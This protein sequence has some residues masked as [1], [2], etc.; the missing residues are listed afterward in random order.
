MTC[1]DCL[2]DCFTCTNDTKCATCNTNISYRQLNSSSRCV[3]LAGYYDDGTSNVAKPCTG[4]C[5]TCVSPGTSCLSC[6]TGSYMNGSSC[7]TCSTVISN[8]ATCT[9]ST[10]CTACKTSF[11]S[12]SATNC[13]CAAGQYLASGQCNFCSSAINRCTTCTS[14]TTCTACSSTFTLFSGTNCSCKTT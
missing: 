11:T 9:S 3:P 6:V 5:A 14:A 7:I 2:Y 13:S 12:Y 10:S 1:N 4:N 8:C